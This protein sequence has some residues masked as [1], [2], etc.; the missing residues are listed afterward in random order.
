MYDM[1]KQR[2][3]CHHIWSQTSEDDGLDQIT[4]NARL[5][6][7]VDDCSVRE[8]SANSNMTRRVI[9]VSTIVVHEYNLSL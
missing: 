6:S 2:R 3:R 8:V 7:S 9:A 5:L 4:N 1:N